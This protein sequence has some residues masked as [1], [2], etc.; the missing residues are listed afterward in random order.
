MNTS[1]TKSEPGFEHLRV[2]PIMKSGCGV[3]FACARTDEEEAL[4]RERARELG[5]AAGVAMPIDP[6]PQIWSVI[7]Y[8]KRSS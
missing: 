8:L 5:L 6:N 4:A 1:N 7:D 3:S 2:I